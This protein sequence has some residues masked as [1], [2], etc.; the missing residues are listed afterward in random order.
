MSTYIKL[1]RSICKWEWFTVDNTFRIFVWLL[2]NANIS[3]EKF[4]GKI[5]K[6][7]QIA[8]SYGTIGKS[9]HLSRQKVITALKHLKSTGEITSERIKNYQLITVVNYEKYQR[10]IKK[11]YE[12]INEL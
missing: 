4:L 11:D 9:C 2:L 6:R 3:D 10:S 8:T 1:Y 7:G 5:I 12:N